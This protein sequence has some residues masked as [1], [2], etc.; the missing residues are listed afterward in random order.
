MK[1]FNQVSARWIFNFLKWL[2]QKL[3]FISV[4]FKPFSIFIINLRSLFVV[5]FQVFQSGPVLSFFKIQLQSLRNY[6]GSIPGFNLISKF[7]CNGFRQRNL[8]FNLFQF[9][10]WRFRHISVFLLITYILISI[11]YSA[12]ERISAFRKNLS[13]AEKILISPGLVTLLEFP[14]AITEVRVGSP[15]SLKVQISKVSPKELTVYLSSSDS[16]PTNLIVRAD[17]RVFVFDVI[18]SKN[19]HQDYVKVRSSFGAPELAFVKSEIIAR[20]V[21]APNHRGGGR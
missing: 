8:N 15:E 19:S 6:F 11:C 12:P 2:L 16:R 10:I 17:R 9:E 5:I 20:G 4:Q 1:L 7:I 21:I 18:P 14:N 13:K 3:I